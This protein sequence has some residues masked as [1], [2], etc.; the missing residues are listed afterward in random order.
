LSIFG[1]GPERGAL[2]R[3]A[4]RLGI[5]DRVRLPGLTSSP[6]E[7]IAAADI[8]VLS[9]RFEGFPNVLLEALAA[10]IPSVAF[11]CPWGPADIIHDERTGLLIAKEDVAALASA[12]VRLLT[13]SDLRH[14]IAACA[15][16]D[17]R[18]S[19]D[20]VLAKWDAVIDEAVAAGGTTARYPPADLTYNT[21]VP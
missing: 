10:G 18:F 17:T 20:T 5:A 13:D 6:G 14:R 1:E 4:D 16:A 11:D 3:Q 2:E 21:G 12:L 19:T 8:F 15:Q 9:S 7:W